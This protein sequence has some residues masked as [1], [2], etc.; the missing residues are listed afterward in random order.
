MAKCEKCKV[1]SE[2]LYTCPYCGKQFCFRH[3]T[4]TIDKFTYGHKCE[5]YIKQ[6]RAMEREKPLSKIPRIPSSEP[7]K[8]ELSLEIISLFKYTIIGIIGIVFL[9]ILLRIL[10]LI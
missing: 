10:R 7:S 4:P 6:M 1:E 8:E 9:L 2:N 3:I 5:E